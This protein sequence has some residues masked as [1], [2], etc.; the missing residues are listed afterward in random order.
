[1]I[2]LEPTLL[3]ITQDENEIEYLRKENAKLR[4]KE[5]QRKIPKSKTEKEREAKVLSDHRAADAH[6]AKLKSTGHSSNSCATVNQ[7]GPK[8]SDA[9]TIQTGTRSKI[10]IKG[11]V[12]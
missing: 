1:M 2:T 9:S 8:L 12:K 7:F 5:K 10:L 3:V 4:A 11:D 6:K